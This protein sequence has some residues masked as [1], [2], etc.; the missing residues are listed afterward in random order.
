MPITVELQ[1]MHSYSIILPVVVGIIGAIVVASIV[2]VLVKKFCKAKPNVPREIT[3]EDREKIKARY[4][5]LLNGL[6]AHCRSGKLSN[7]K[8]YQ[9]LSKIA[10]NYIYETTGVK[11]QNYTL[12]EI[13]STNMAGLYNVVNDCY[14][15][16]FSIDKNGD[17]YSSIAKARKVVEGWN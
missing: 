12:D 11:V 8:A 7:R 17:I 13:R 10:R 16:E 15:P 9:E 5:G 2:F 3:V 14:A 1:D 6:E 4:I